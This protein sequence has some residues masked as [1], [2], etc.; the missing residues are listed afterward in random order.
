[1]DTF[2]LFRFSTFGYFVTLWIYMLLVMPIIAMSFAV[3]LII[4]RTLIIDKVPC[5]IPRSM[6]K[7]AKISQTKI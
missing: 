7:S 6:L 5:F 2:I 4:A 3:S 1:M